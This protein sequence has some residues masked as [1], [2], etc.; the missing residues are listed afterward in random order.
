VVVAGAAKATTG[1]PD[2][3]M[4]VVCGSY[5]SGDV[6]LQ[7]FN[8][9]ASADAAQ[10]THATSTA[11][12]LGGC[13]RNSVI[14]QRCR[15]VCF[16]VEPVF[17]RTEYRYVGEGRGSYSRVK[18][19][20]F[21]GEG[22]GKYDKEVTTIYHGWKFRR[23]CCLVTMVALLACLLVPLFVLFLSILQQESGANDSPSVL[24]SPNSSAA[25]AAA[26]TSGI[27]AYDCQ[28]G[29]SNWEA[30]WSLVKKAYCCEYSNISCP[31]AAK[32]TIA[33]KEPQNASVT[34]PAPSAAPLQPAITRTL[35]S[36][37]P[38]LDLPPRVL[39]L[40]R[41]PSAAVVAKRWSALKEIALQRMDSSFGKGQN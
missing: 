26:T 6:N 38:P 40:F 23:A 13:A 10:G 22:V 14:L 29:L 33:T 4:P 35:Q 30:G 21:V 15:H 32:T 34:P 1:C 9:M 27:I 17:A 31:D 11:G 18:S 8:S 28:A 37:L 36:R 41:Q 19:Y 25:T 5:K 24:P 39:P 20:N 7:D 16:N 3:A 2:D 12:V